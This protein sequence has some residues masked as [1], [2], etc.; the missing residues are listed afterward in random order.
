MCSLGYCGAT[1]LNITLPVKLDFEEKT[2][3]KK[4]RPKAIVSEKCM[5][6]AQ[7]LLK[8]IKMP[9]G[10]NEWFTF[11]PGSHQLNIWNCSIKTPPDK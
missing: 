5:F 11:S 10:I 3:T 6:S 2:I 1:Q 8:N 4:F 7:K 9:R